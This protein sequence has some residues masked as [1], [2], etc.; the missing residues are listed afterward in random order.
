MALIAIFSMLWALAT[1]WFS[2]RGTE[3]PVLNISFRI[4]AMLAVG[5][6]CFCITKFKM[7]DPM[8]GT[9]WFLLLVLLSVFVALF[10]LVGAFVIPI[11]GMMS[12]GIS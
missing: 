9:K 6:F 11:L 1:L 2:N 5:S 8:S 12:S 3:S 4:P 10:Y 7:L